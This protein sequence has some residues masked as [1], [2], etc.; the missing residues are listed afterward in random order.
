[1]ERY[2]ETLAL[3]YNTFVNPAHVTVFLV[4]GSIA[5]VRCALVFEC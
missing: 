2:I 4:Q 3:N 1:M 5:Y